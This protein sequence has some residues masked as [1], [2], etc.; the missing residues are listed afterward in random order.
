[1]FRV[2]KYIKEAVTRIES[3]FG[4]L[5]KSSMPMAA[6]DHPEIDDSE[7]LS[8][9]DHRKFQML[10]GIM[11]WVVTIGRLDIAFATMSLSRFSACPR[12]GHLE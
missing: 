5:T 9:D 8:D 2:Q 11:N 4:V 12:C 10:I 7:V 1:M 3:M 6:G